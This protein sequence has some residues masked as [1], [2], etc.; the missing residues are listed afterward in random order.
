MLVH[1]ADSKALSFFET[2]SHSDTVPQPEVEAT[3]ANNDK[4]N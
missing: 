4:Q 3:F 1:S 2:F